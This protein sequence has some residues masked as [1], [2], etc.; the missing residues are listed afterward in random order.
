MRIEN[1]VTN[2]D[3]KVFYTLYYKDRKGKISTMLGY[4]KSDLL[5]IATDSRRVRQVLK[6]VAS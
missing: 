2:P 1:K 5:R 4:S 3:K 6:V